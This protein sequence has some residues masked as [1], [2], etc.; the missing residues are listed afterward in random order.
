M[1]TVKV[2]ASQSGSGSRTVFYQVTQRGIVR[3]I[4]TGM[5][6]SQEEWDELCARP[7]S[8]PCAPSVLRC[9][10]D[11]DVEVLRDIIRRLE[12]SGGEYSADDVVRRF[13]S[14]GCRTM[15][16]S[17]IGKVAGHLESCMRFGTARNYR[18]MMSSLSAYL[19]GEDFPLMA[20]SEEFVDGYNAFLVQRGILRNSISFYMR[21]L[22]A[23]YNRAVRENLAEPSNPFRNVYT[24]I[25]RTRK[26]A[27]DEKI[28]TR[29]FRLGLGDS[30]SLS[31]A[32]D[33][34]IF[35]YCARGMAFVDM[36]YLRKTDIRDGS[37]RY[38][39]HKT[40]QLLC[41]R[42]EPN[43]RD[44]MDRYDDPSSCYVFPILNTVDPE[45]AFSQYQVALNN[46]NRQLKRLSSMLQ[47]DCGL[48]SY[49]ARHSW[50]TAARNRHVP[51]SVIS[52][53]M[54]H[55]S[56]RTTQIYLAM[57]E[58]SLIDSANRKIIAGLG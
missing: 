5:R 33:L 30:P 45:K 22:R 16:L 32:R 17:Y 44:I 57:I 21:I 34:F 15:I 53:G 39:R 9:R 41:I 43:L 56:E 28:I 13:G 52:A 4:V 35:S 23:V 26:R 55:S 25:D 1:A 6:I 31:M 29:L 46:Y 14:P 49:V 48:S 11:G 8:G 18:R 51:L 37:I 7:G 2:K 12:C 10:I 40:G 20:F 42:V 58:D 38:V 27:V 3:R 19:H 54:G 47:L 50:A 36:A 24:G